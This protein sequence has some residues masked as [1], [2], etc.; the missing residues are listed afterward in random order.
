VGQAS[1]SFKL[2]SILSEMSNPK[3][4]IMCL[5]KPQIAPL[6]SNFLNILRRNRT[7]PSLFPF[8]FPPFLHPLS[9]LSFSFILFSFP[10]RGG[11]NYGCVAGSA[12]ARC[13]DAIVTVG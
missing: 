4:Q 7:H 1:C 9:F 2:P 5:K 10:A 13:L 6:T 8:H 3:A 12:E 11:V